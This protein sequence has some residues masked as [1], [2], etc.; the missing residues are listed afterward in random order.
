MSLINVL[1]I[2]GILKNF[3]NGV[4]LKTRLGLTKDPMKNCNVL[5]VYC[6]HESNFCLISHMNHLIAR[7]SCK[8]SSLD[9]CINRLIARK[10]CKS[11]SLDSHMNRLIARI[12]LIK[13]ILIKDLLYTFLYLDLSK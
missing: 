3:I 4:I 9:S 12:M 2:L 13:F 8:S 1:E 5:D 6:R 7:K 11:S 10:S